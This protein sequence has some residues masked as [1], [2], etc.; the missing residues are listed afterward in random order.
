MRPCHRLSQV[1]ILRCPSEESLTALDGIAMET[2]SVGLQRLSFKYMP[3][4]TRRSRRS[5]EKLYKASHSSLNKAVSLYLTSIST[6][7]TPQTT[8]LQ[9]SRDFFRHSAHDI[10]FLMK[11]ATSAAM[12]SFRSTATTGVAIG[13]ATTN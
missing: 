9:I 10:I 12:L 5:Q 2:T 1:E 8:S 7:T 4:K 11:S 6:T 3:K 13:V